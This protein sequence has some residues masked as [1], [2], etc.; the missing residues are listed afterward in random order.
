MDRLGRFSGCFDY[1]FDSCENLFEQ[2]K[3]V[4]D[5]DTSVSLLFSLLFS[6]PFTL[7]IFSIYKPLPTSHSFS[8]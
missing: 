6:S 7:L 3:T 5:S 2:L 8:M 1:R 4:L